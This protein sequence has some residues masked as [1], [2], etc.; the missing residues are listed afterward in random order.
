MRNY[1]T[2]DDLRERIDE[3]GGD[4]GGVGGGQPQQRVVVLPVHAD[5]TGSSSV[6]LKGQSHKIF[7]IV[8]IFL[9]YFI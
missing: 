8:L 4:Q 2:N 5:S 9:L 7:S 1:L 6:H 3:P